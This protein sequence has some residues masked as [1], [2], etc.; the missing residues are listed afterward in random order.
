MKGDPWPPVW[1]GAL[2]PKTPGLQQQSVREMSLQTASLHQE[3]RDEGERAIGALVHTYR[4]DMLLSLQKL[5][6]RQY[7]KIYYGLSGTPGV[8]Q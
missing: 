1:G 5:E 7:A 3:T 6:G 2:T 4:K 8:R